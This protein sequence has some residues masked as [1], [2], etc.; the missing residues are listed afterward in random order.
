MQSIAKFV[1]LLFAVALAAA[2][3]GDP[4]VEQRDTGT[5]LGA[6]DAAPHAD[7][8]PADA[9]DEPDVDDGPRSCVL[10]GD[11]RTGEVCV[12]ELCAPSP[13]C[14]G[15]QD[16][17]RCTAA[18]HE[19]SPELGARATCGR[20]GY[21]ILACSEDR[22]CAA[23]ET[24]SDLGSC[25]PFGG[26]LTA[27]RP[28]GETRRP[29]RAGV[30]NVLLNFPIGVSLAGY[31]SRVSGVN[32]RY[33]S[34][35]KPSVGAFHA[36][37]AR[38]AALDNG[39]RKTVI[40][41][42]PVVFAS[43]WLHEAVA[44]RLGDL[45]GENWR[46]DLVISAT[47]THSGPARFWPL[48]AD[49]AVDMG[50]VGSDSYHH[51]IFEWL[52][53]STVEAA[54]A[55]LDDLRPARFGWTIVEAYDTDDAIAA[56][57]WS[58]SPP[59]DDNRAL[60]VRIDDADG[61][62]IGGMISLGIHSTFNS[63]DYLTGDAAGALEQAL[64][65]DFGQR[66]GRFLPVMFL[67]QNGGSMSPRGS[68]HG[69]QSLHQHEYL[70]YEFAR[71][72]TDRFDAI[73]TH[74]DVE[75]ASHTHYFPITY[76]RVG[77]EI[78][79]WT[80]P[81]LRSDAQTY[82]YGAIQC[83]ND[84][85]TDYE[86]H[87]DPYSMICV[88]LHFMTQNRPPMLFQRSAISALK[89]GGLTILTLPGE[90]SMEIGWQV[91]R[92]ARDRF[93]VD[94]MAA[95]V[96]GYAQ[97]HQLYITPTNLRGERPPFPGIS[98]PTALDDYPDFAFSWLQGGY[99]AQMSVW[100]HLFGDYIV[101]RAVE[102]LQHLE[103]PANAPPAESL[104]SEF[105]PYHTD[106]FPIEPSPADAVGEV[107][108]PL[109]AQL[110]RLSPVE[111]GWVGG[112]PGVEMPQTPNVALERE[113][114]PGVFAA[115]TRPNHRPYTNREPV[116]ATRVRH[117]ADRWEWLVYWEELHNF[118]LGTYRFVVSGHHQVAGQRTPYTVTSDPFEL[119]AA[120]IHA[121]VSRDANRATGTLTYPAGAPL[122]VVGTPTDP[123]RL[124]GTLRMRHPD[125]PSAQAPPVEAADVTA[126]EVRVLDGAT[127]WQTFDAAAANLTTTTEFPRRT[128]F[129]V[130]LT[131]APPNAQVVVVAT[132]RFGNGTP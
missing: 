40:V 28:G 91:L 18:F 90:P 119:G 68:R 33:A 82:F 42:L 5:D 2:C 123:G 54:V 79:Q 17:R 120:P 3:S 122:A 45:T 102:A 103:D 73:E 36:L 108:A 64:E 34:T 6:D 48:P 22:E 125:S 112:D 47:H 87:A 86:T 14:D 29:L 15:L 38:A 113:V 128:T 12:D 27:P 99:E 105:T 92:A 104:P 44:R 80:P 97:D 21:C 1:K 67:S 121:A 4:V 50:R 13:T 117:N 100:G 85:D 16:W 65:L 98:T 95:F 129:E 46:D 88:P 69:H 96:W 93:G 8:D 124:E 132:D 51:V 53:E 114:G 49:G 106:D 41:R 63:D 56:D 107:V 26:D 60:L 109:P 39:E 59:F 126:F 10:Q 9:S 55:A 78:G 61:V 115:V 66:Y 75:L 30:S 58:A 72:V 118:P 94:P 77:Y 71:R 57:R 130:D 111:F 7:V 116:M 24:C 19:I 101:E 81:H 32:H 131:G 31:G 37:Y 89:L 110:S 83:F 20:A 62:P 43:A 25:I 52:V 76:P 70:G 74:S 23:G 84:G 127:V 11:C 35:L